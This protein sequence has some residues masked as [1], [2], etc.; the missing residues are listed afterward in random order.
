MTTSTSLPVSGVSGLLTSGYKLHSSSNFT[1]LA[2]AVVENTTV[3]YQL[4]ASL[5][6][7]VSSITLTAS[8]TGL[9]GSGSLSIATTLPVK[10]LNIVY[11]TN[12]SQ[13][14]VNA[15]AQLQL[16]C[17][18]CTAFGP[19]ANQTAFQQVWLKTFANASW[20]SMIKNQIYTNSTG[21]L[22]VT[23][24][25]GTEVNSS[26]SANVTLRFVAV[27]TGPSADF[28]T[29]LES[30]LFKTGIPSGLDAII[31]SAISLSTGES[32]SLS[33]NPQT[34]LLIIKASATFVGNLDAQ[35]NSLKKQFFQLYLPLLPASMITP[36]E[37][38]LNST[39]VTVSKIQTT[40]DLDLNAGTWKSTFG[41]LILNPPT[42]GPSSNFT[43]HGL[44]QTLGSAPLTPSGV[45]IT[46]AG[47]SDNTYQVKIVVPNDG[48]PAPS[49]TTSNSATW[50]N[51]QNASKLQNVE[52][53]L[54][55]LPTSIFAFFTTPFGIAV[56]AIIAAAIIGSVLLL[57]RRRRMKMPTGLPPSGPTT[58]PGMGPSPTPT[59]P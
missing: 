23:T 53:Q 43:I 33:Y 9:A 24:F 1:Q 10:N 39:T 37:L 17:S 48:T 42:E 30:A 16:G 54:Q 31:R 19:L 51:V 59:T 13:I 4:P 2:N 28:V 57:L 58:T 14:Q 8:Q 36:T 41:G 5:S 49:S 55:R 50:L 7:I 12:P 29:A 21:A 46:L 38:F 15:T 56:D 11:L 45:N 40:S 32:A 3:Q 27:P 34:G 47:G 20:T 52:F 22:T 35:L 26:T 25:S 44:F 6:S 18:L